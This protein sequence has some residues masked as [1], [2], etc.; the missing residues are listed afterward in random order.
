MFTWKLRADKSWGFH[1]TLPFVPK[2]VN[3]SP[4]I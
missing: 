1:D 4:P 2:Y 3:T